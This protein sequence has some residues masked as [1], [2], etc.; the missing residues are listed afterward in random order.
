M[1]ETLFLLEQPSGFS[2]DPNVAELH[3]G[4][5]G[6]VQNLSIVGYG[7][8]ILVSDVSTAHSPL[9]RWHLKVSGNLAIEFGVVREG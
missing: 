6:A 4:P 8:K 2:R 3:M 7:P 9:L 1:F 5:N